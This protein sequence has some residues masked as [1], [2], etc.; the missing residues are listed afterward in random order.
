MERSR[1]VLSITLLLLQYS[2]KGTGA[3]KTNI[4]TDQSALLAMRSHITSD[5]HNISVNWSTST[6]VCNWVGVTCGARH[7]RVVSLNLSYMGFTGTIPPHLGNLS[8][9]VALSFNNNSFYGTLPHELSYLRR[10]KFIS[11]RFNNFMG[12]I[13][14]WFGSFPKLQKL[15]L[16]GNQ[17]SG[18]IP[19]TIFNL[20]TLE[21][22]SLS[23]NK[24]SGAIPKEIGNL[25]M[26]KRI[27][28]DSNNFNEIP[29]EIGFLHQ[30]EKLYVQLNALKGPVPVVVF[31][32][33]SLTTLTLYGNNL[34]GGL[35]N[36]IFQ[37]LPSLQILNLGRNQFDGPLPSKLWQCR[38]LLMLNLEENNFSGSIPK[39]IGNLTMMKEISLSHNNLTGTIPDEIGDLPNLQILRFQGNNLN[40]LIPSSIFNISTISEISLSFNQ[41][42][43]S[44]PANIGLGLPNLQFLFIDAT[45]LSGV[46]PNLSNASMLAKIDLADNSF[47]GFLP[48]TLCA[49][50]NLQALKLF[51][52]NLTID[53]SIPE[54]NTLSCLANLGNL[55]ILSLHSNPLN[56]RLDDSLRNFS[57]SS[58]QQFSLA[59]CSMR[60]NIPIGIGNLSSLISLD[61]GLN[62]LS[63]TIPTSLG[64]LGI[65]QELILN[66]NKLQGHIPDQLCQLDNLAFL[67]LSDNKLSGSIPS[68]LGNLTAS[69]RN[70]SLSFNSLSS[71]IPSTFWRLVD[72]QYV[73]LSSNSLIGPLSQDIG[74]LKVVRHV[75]LSNN[76]LSG[77]IPITIGGL[78]DLDY[79]SLA[80]NNLEGPIPSA[81]DG[82]LSLEELDLS[83]NNLSGVIPKS[84]EALSLLRYMDLSFNRLQGEIP[85]GGPFQNFSAQSFV[86]NKA[87]CGAARLQVPPC[88]NGTLEPNWRKAKYIIPGIISII[89]FV[90]S[91]SIFVLRRKRNVEVAREATSLPQ[92]VWRRVSHLELLRGTNGFNENNLLGRGGFG[93]VYKGTLL[94]GIDVAVKVFSLQLEGAFKNFDRECEMLSNI[95]HRNLIKIISCCSELDFK[96]LVLNYMPNGSLEKWL[97]SQDYSLN[98]LQRLNIMIDA[99]SA[100]EYLHH[101]YSIRI[102]HCD[103][104]PSNILLDDDMVAHVADFGIAK[105]LDGGDSITQTMTLATIGYMA[106]EYGLEGM[107]STRGD[108]YSFGIV[109]MET[110]TRR[111]PT[112]EMFDGE[113]N[114]KQWIAN[115]LVLPYSN[116][117]EVVDANLLGIGT[118]QEDDDHVRKRDCISAIMRLALTCCA[119]SPEERISMKEVVAT[120]NKI[121]TKFLKDAAAGRRGVLLNRPLVQQR[122]N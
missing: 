28:L 78:Q 85:T 68:C 79:L 30:L 61:L 106:P 4:T 45:D 115:S 56:A 43:G 118:E 51:D 105:L 44:L 72:I 67:Y 97:Y 42:S 19:S 41:L 58:L 84:L 26:L 93:S 83:R 18:T 24:L 2:S 13:P 98:I 57:T 55:T 101:G 108:V 73:S 33:S 119:E 92:L 109:V 36:K 113:M 95:R 104:K 65:L 7:L 103:M 100:L 90:A 96:A 66:V 60:G 76:H 121:K 62:Q 35:P 38:E 23:S 5:P 63:G 54:A 34:S 20:S 94:D 82:L 8:F 12:S 89:L 46:I 17:F 75:D 10:L 52:N 69:L 15:V 22:I 50:T 74:N 59:N 53:T 9:L 6:S 116:I 40:G 29:K 16:Y 31:N 48:S 99:A 47:T 88:E 102:V 87:L 1:F 14:S 32:M 114:I 71:T 64:R 49:L 86:S 122:F 120:L 110:F 70:L 80:S 107:V 3:A 111:K 91:I 117:D 21:D 25:T 81:F 11:L 39:N 37:Y 112:D 27:Y 77:V